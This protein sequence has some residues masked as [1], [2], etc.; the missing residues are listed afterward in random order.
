MVANKMPNDLT[1][2]LLGKYGKDSFYDAEQNILEP[3]FELND[4]LK[5]R[6]LVVKIFWYHRLKYYLS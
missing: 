4:V 2:R 3:K 6:L 1:N 5:F